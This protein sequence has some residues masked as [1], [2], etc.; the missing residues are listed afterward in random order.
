[1]NAALLCLALYDLATMNYTIYTALSIT[2]Y[3]D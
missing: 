3:C 2:N 1:M